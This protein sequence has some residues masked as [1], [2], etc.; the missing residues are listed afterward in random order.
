MSKLKEFKK[1]LRPG[2]VYRRAELARRSRSV[3]RH[4]QELLKEGVLKRLAGGVYYCPRKASFG[5]VPPE[6]EKLVRAFLKDD[7]FYVASLNAYNALGVGTTQLYNEKLVYNRKRDGRHTLNGRNFYFLK[8]RP[9]PRKPSEEFLMV[10]LMNNLDFL[11][12]DKETVRN[13]VAEKALSMDQGKLR[14]AVRQFGGARTKKFFEDLL[15]RSNV[16]YVL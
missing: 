12:E 5:E 7:D 11:M 10:D 4:L 6:D 14:K 13:K 16:S 1:H 15:N 2:Q 3:D 9:I 8:N